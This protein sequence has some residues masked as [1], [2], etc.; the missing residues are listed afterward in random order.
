[1]NFFGGKITFHL[2]RVPMEKPFLAHRLNNHRQWLVLP[3][4]H[5]W[6]VLA[7]TRGTFHF[8]PWTRHPLGSP[9]DCAV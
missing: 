2:T 7:L 1:M 9:S 8:L 4:G 3:V 5:N 6:Q